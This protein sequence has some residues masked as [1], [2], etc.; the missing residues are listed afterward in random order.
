MFVSEEQV[1]EGLEPRVVWGYFSK[2][3]QIP[4]TSGD[5]EK[6]REFVETEAVRLNLELKK[7]D[8]GNIVIKKQAH[9]AREGAEKIILQAHLDMVGQ[10]KSGSEFNFLTDAI[11]PVIKDE[12]VK[13]DGTTLGADNGIGV[14]AALAVLASSDLP[15]PEL[16][17]LFTASEEIGMIGARALA[18]NM[19]EG[20]V[21][22]N[23]DNETLGEMAI[24]CAGGAD[25]SASLPFSY[26]ANEKSGFTLLI[27]GLKGGHSGIDIDKKR[28]NAL[29][30]IGMLL[31]RIADCINLHSIE[32]GDMRNAICRE[33][34]AQFA[35][36]ALYSDL[37]TRIRA[38]LAEIKNE[39]CEE[40]QKVKF[41]FVRNDDPMPEAMSE[42]TQARIFQFL[43]AF[44][45]GV[46]AMSQEYENTVETSNNLA[47]I[48]IDGRKIKFHSLARSLDD[49]KRATLEIEIQELA[50]K[51]SGKVQ[52]SEEYPAWQVADGG[53]VVAICYHQGA[54]LGI[55][56]RAKIIHAGL[57]CGLIKRL[58]SEIDAISIGPTI[59]MPH[60]PS[61]RVNIASVEKFWQWLIAILQA[62]ARM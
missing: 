22:I 11:K 32:G 34:K 54:N 49:K 19:L 36:D 15:H 13:A 20:K 27:S 43:E 5:E 12:W 37:R 10:K 18:P 45:D 61:E 8:A 52:F 47:K 40:D 48:F 4:R 59:E 56:P 17:V 60:S 42:D 50:A 41:T 28:G 23:L 21:L 46:I 1:L 39:L 31:A 58:N 16:E 2:I 38:A 51:F 6:I 44:P 24:G 9:K 14:A 7:D 3:L 33:A 57:E 25:I 62:Y 26:Q 55:E 53:E 35:S 29:K 30:I